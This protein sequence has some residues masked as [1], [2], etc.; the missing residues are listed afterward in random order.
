MS[1]SDWAFTGAYARCSAKHDSAGVAMLERLYLQSAR[2]NLDAT[3]ASARR[4]F[5]H[6]IPYVLLMHVS[7]LS[8]HMMPRV[9]Q[10]YRSAGVRLVPLAKAESDPFYAGYTDL[11]GPPPRS[12]EELAGEKGISLTPAPDHT[13]QIDAVCT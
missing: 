12:F 2:E 3:R 9:I 11:R 7:A 8:A 10:L 5:G 1:F 4:L 13:K 6:D